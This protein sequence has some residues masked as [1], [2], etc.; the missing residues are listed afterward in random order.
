MGVTLFDNKTDQIVFHVN[1]WHYRAIVEA[2]RSLGG[3]S[4]DKIDS[5]HEQWCGNGLTVDE[6][7]A[8]AALMR[9][10]IMPSLAPG[11]RLLSDGTFSDDPD[12]GT[13]HR[14][15]DQHRNYSTNAEVLGRFIK[16]CE[17][18]NGF[19]VC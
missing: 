17:T 13:L 11:W 4:N 3:L 5:L 7:R 10:Q 8:V 15:K 1:F 19:R 18:C 14:G 16:C 12:D 2:I 9:S 6:A